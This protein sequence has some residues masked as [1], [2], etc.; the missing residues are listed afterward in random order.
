MR[1]YSRAIPDATIAAMSDPATRWDL[2]WT[3]PKTYVFVGAAAGASTFPA[4][5]VAI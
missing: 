5:S 2:Y 1:Y 3:G 4:L